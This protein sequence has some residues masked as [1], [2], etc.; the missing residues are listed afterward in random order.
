MHN[1]VYEY[2]VIDS[3]TI[4]I[5]IGP[6]RHIEIYLSDTL[7]IEASCGTFHL[8]NMSRGD[9]SYISDMFCCE[10]S[11]LIC[12]VSCKGNRVKLACTCSTGTLI[13]EHGLYDL[14]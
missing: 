4:S 9:R 6:I 13:L 14:L 1:Y 11:K 2:T 12:F 10:C 7:R 3:N 8:S 5:Q